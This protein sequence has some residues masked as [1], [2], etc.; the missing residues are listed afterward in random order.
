MKLPW[1]FT[2]F[3]WFIPKRAWLNPTWIQRA[4]TLDVGLDVNH[5]TSATQTRD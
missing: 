4:D 5:I 2:Q 1:L 3:I